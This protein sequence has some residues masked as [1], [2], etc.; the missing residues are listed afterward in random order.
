MQLGKFDM[1]SAYRMIPVQPAD[2][3]LLEMKWEGAVYVDGALL[4][5]LPSAPK[6]LTIL[7]MDHGKS[8]LPQSNALLRRLLIFGSAGTGKCTRELGTCMVIC[9]ASSCTSKD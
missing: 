9:W 5:K 3:P 8:R 1:E 7:F 4:F 6:L 2:R